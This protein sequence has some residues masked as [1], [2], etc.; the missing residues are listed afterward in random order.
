MTPLSQKVT[1][2]IWGYAKRNK[3]RFI[4]KEGMPYASA[5]QKKRNKKMHTQR[6]YATCLA[7]S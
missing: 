4:S 3:K 6:R 5:C 1:S 2:K 7:M